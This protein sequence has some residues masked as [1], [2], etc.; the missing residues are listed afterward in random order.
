M[1]ATLF[2][3]AGAVLALGSQPSHAQTLDE[4]NH[5]LLSRGSADL[6]VTVQSHGVQHEAADIVYGHI[7]FFQPQVVLSPEA[8]IG[9]ARNLQLR[10]NAT[11][12]FAM[13]YSYPT[14]EAWAWIR[15][16]QT[17][18]FVAADVSFRPTRTVQLDGGVLW[19]RAVTDD[20]YARDFQTSAS[21]RVTE[22][23]HLFW[24]RSTWLP[25]ANRE[26]RALRSDLDGL[27][28]PLLAPNRWRI[29]GEFQWRAQSYAYRET[30][31][32]APDY[33]NE[34]MDAG[35]ARLRAGVAY[36]LVRGTQVLADVYWH[37]AFSATQTHDS[38]YTYYGSTF[39]SSRTYSDRYHG[40]YGLR[41]GGTWRTRQLEATIDASRERQDVGSEWF[42]TSGLRMGGTWLPDRKSVV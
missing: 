36:G 27:H 7:T 9:L 42:R 6:S 20:A 37:P 28:H 34:H 12:Q 11:N 35:V 33:L 3:L 5:P 26:N 8:A 10:V 17:L 39:P 23:A 24:I 41:V 30:V 31:D 19:G 14:F 18:R 4:L 1:R 13:P 29:D 38:L 21:Y 40:V 25:R 15:D 16:T 2:L 32:G 22:A